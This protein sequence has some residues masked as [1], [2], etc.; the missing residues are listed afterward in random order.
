MQSA[1]SAVVVNAGR[2]P[3]VSCLLTN[4]QPPVGPQI[5]VLWDLD[6]VPDENFISNVL[7]D[8]L[9]LSILKSVMMMRV[10]L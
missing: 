10:I 7:I 6:I 3:H 1:S 2:T 4:F 9:Y 5:E 8:L